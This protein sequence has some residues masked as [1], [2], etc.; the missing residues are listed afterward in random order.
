MQ[1]GMLPTKVLGFIY[2]LALCL[3]CVDLI[4]DGFVKDCLFKVILAELDSDTSQ[5]SPVTIPDAALPTCAPLPPSA[6]MEKNACIVGYALYY[7]TFNTWY[8]KC[9]FLEDLFVREEHRS[10]LRREGLS[11]AGEEGLGVAEGRKGW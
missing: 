3:S 11:I 6:S 9:L 5:G 8:G 1:Y 10:K 2:T 7:F 4:R